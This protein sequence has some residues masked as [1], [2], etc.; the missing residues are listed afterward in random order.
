MK[1]FLDFCKK[2]PQYASRPWFPYAM[3]F[4]AFS[5]YFIFVVP[6]D[7]IV[8]ASVMAARRRWISITFWTSLGSTCGAILF[9][10]L[11]QHFGISFLESWAPHLLEGSFVITLT[12][13]LKDY[14]FWALLLLAASPI[15]QHP[16]VAIAA[17]AKVPLLTIFITMFLGRF[18]K[19]CIYTWL[20]AHAKKGIERFFRE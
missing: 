14:G 7:A 16:V 12:H 20:T 17:L 1:K 2:L 10:A 9:A 5:D 19:Y 3:A 18:L 15:H 4:T 11:L 8:V 6:L 13:W